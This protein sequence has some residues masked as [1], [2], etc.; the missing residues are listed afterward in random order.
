MQRPRNWYKAD[1]LLPRS[2]RAEDA[3]L[4]YKTRTICLASN[5]YVCMRVRVC[6]CVCGVRM[7]GLY[8]LCGVCVCVG[9]VCVYVCVCVC[10]CVVCVCEM[11]V[12]CDVCVCVCAAATATS[13]QQSGIT[14]SH[15]TK[16]LQT[17]NTQN[18]QGGPMSDIG[19][20]L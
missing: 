20:I 9:C 13:S 8:G 11:C 4:G 12:V 1:L 14:L 16:L 19:I 2:Q 3:I 6:V 15:R 5:A 10:V 17:R 7:C 18:S